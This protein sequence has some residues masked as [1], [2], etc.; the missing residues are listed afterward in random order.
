[1]NIRLIKDSSLRMGVI[2]QEKHPLKYDNNLTYEKLKPYVVVCLHCTP[3]RCLNHLHL[4]C[5]CNEKIPQRGDHQQNI[6]LHLGRKLHRL[7]VCMKTTV[8]SVRLFILIHSKVTNK[9]TRNINFWI[10]L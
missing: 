2:F 9:K 10:Y 8:V 3:R 6:G 7:F 4:V 5:I 1:M